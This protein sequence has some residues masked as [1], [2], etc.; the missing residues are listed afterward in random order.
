M[1][2]TNRPWLQAFT[3][4]FK[5]CNPVS[6]LKL[7]C[8][9]T[10]EEMVVPVSFLYHFL[11][12][13]QACSQYIRQNFNAPEKKNQSCILFSASHCSFKI[14][15][16]IS[17]SYKPQ[18]QGLLYLDPRDPEIL[19]F[20]IAWIRELPVLLILLGDKNTSHSQVII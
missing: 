19:N 3:N 6:S 8:L 13:L 15:F 4:A 16:D 18:R 12:F 5:D 2:L 14:D 11:E 9:S 1:V 20:Q 17:F 7:A 10:M